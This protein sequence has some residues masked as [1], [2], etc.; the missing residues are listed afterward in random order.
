MMNYPIPFSQAGT[1]YFYVNSTNKMG[2]FDKP[3]DGRVQLTVDY[4]KLVPSVSVSKVW[5]EIE[6]GGVPPLTI[7]SVM[8]ADPLVTFFVAGG[9]SDMSY[10]VILNSVLDD[11]EIHSDLLVVNVF[12][13]DGC[14]CECTSNIYADNFIQYG[15]QEVFVNKYP[16][17]FVSAT[18]PPNANLLDRWYDLLNQTWYDY[19]TDGVTNFWAISGV[20][21]PPP[22]GGGDSG[23][24]GNITIKRM[25]PLAL[26]GITTTFP[27]IS[28]DLFTPNVTTPNS[29]FVSIDGVWQEPTVQFDASGGSITFTTAPAVDSYVFILWIFGGITSG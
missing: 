3:I 23:A 7:D 10:N 28:T 13:E 8:V 26:D 15:T 29:L 4:S 21:S 11:G 24:S 1:S 18:A 12:G 5:F 20:G 9:Y 17:F 2:S 6:P 16:R 14:A 22:S 27:L 19:V 25:Q